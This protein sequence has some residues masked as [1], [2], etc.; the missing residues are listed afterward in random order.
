MNQYGLRPTANNG[1]QLGDASYRWASIYGS[2]YYD[3]SGLFQD[4]QDDLIVMSEIQPRK[5][6]TIDPETGVKT[7]S[8]VTYV[9]KESGLEYID[10]LSL[11]RWMTNYD[12]VFVRLKED[13]GDLLSDTDIEDLI[14]DH[15]EAGWMLSRNIGR[16]NFFPINRLRK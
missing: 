5:K 16:F 13:N 7:K 6:V 3:E 10:N 11:P 1:M 12:E 14:E 2:A 9:D 4:L 15:D 8:E